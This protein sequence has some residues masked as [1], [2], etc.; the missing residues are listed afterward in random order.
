MSGNNTLGYRTRGNA[1]PQ[2][3]PRVY[4]CGHPDD[5]AGQ[6]EV[7]ADEILGL[8]ANAAIWY[9][10]PAY[11]PD[12][13]LSPDELAQMQLVVVPVTQRFLHEDCAARLEELPCAVEQHVPV[14]PVL[15]DIALASEFNRLCGDLQCLDRHA[16]EHDPT[17]LPYRE[18]LARFLG[19]VLVDDDLAARVRAAFDA[20]VFLSYRKRDRAEA[21]QVMRLIHANPLCRDIAIW[22]DEF[23][24]PGESFNQAIMDALQKS[25][26]FALVVTPSLLQNPNYVM[27]T[28]WPA[29]RDAGKPTLPIEALPTDPGQLASLY[30]GLGGTIS[31]KDRDAVGKRLEE[32][33]RGIA[34]KRRAGEPAHDYLI[35][36]AYLSGIDVE[37]DRD[38]AL[39]LITAAAEAD[40]PEACE[41]LVA[42]YRNG[43]GVV[44]SYR[45]A[46]AWQERLIEILKGRE[47][48]LRFPSARL[49]KA[50]DSLAMLKK[51]AGDAVGSR[52]AQV[53][54]LEQAMRIVDS[55]NLDGRFDIATSCI[56]LGS[57]LLGSGDPSTARAWLDK[58]R[59][60]LE[61]VLA[62]EQGE[63]FS[64]VDG[65]NGLDI[66]TFGGFVDKKLVR[67][68]LVAC[69]AHIGNTYA[70]ED[71]VD[72][73]HAWFLRSIDLL[74][75]LAA[76]EGSFASA[77]HLVLVY[78]LMARLELGEGSTAEARHWCSKG[79]AAAEELDEKNAR[80]CLMSLNDA[81]ASIC[82]A[83]GSHEEVRTYRAA[84]AS[85]AGDTEIL[86]RRR[87]IDLLIESAS[88]CEEAHDLVGACE[89]Y[90]QACV[91]SEGLIEE[92]GSAEVRIDLS[93]FRSHLVDLFLD[94]FEYDKAWDSAK[95][96]VA[97]AEQAAA[98]SDTYEAHEALGVAYERMALVHRIEHRPKDSIAS[99]E[100]TVAEFER[101]V[102]ENPDSSWKEHITDAKAAI[103]ELR[104]EIAE[105]EARRKRWHDR[106]LADTVYTL[107]KD[108]A[109]IA[110]FRELVDRYDAI[111]R[112]YRK[113][114][115]RVD[116]IYWYERELSVLGALSKTDG[117]DDVQELQE[118]ALRGLDETYISREVDPGKL[119]EV[120]PEPPVYDAGSL[121]SLPL[122]A[123]RTLSE[124]YTRYINRL[125]AA[126]DYPSMADWFQRLGEVDSVLIERSGMYETAEPLYDYIRAGRMY[127]V[128]GDADNAFAYYVMASVRIDKIDALWASGGWM[129]EDGE[130]YEPLYSV[131]DE[132]R[133]E[134]LEA[135]EWN[136]EDALKIRLKLAEKDPTLWPIRIVAMLCYKSA[137]STS[138]LKKRVAYLEEALDYGKRCIE[139]GGTEHDQLFV[140]I[141]ARE[142]H[143]WGGDV[144][145][146]RTAMKTAVVFFSLDGNTRLAACGL[147]ERL[148]ADAFE[149]RTVKPY[150]AKGPLKI[151]VGGKDATFDTCPAI[152]PLDIDLA[153]YDQ[154]VLGTPVWADKV[155][156]PINT[157]LKGRG[158]GGKS[159]ALL[160]S[161]AGGDATKCAQDA[162][163]KL[164]RTTEELP[165]LSLR[166]PTKMGA[167]DLAAQ[168]DAFATQ[169]NS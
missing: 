24:V 154:V 48:D 52:K 100:K 84:A 168:L 165:L 38:R 61:A 63:A 96:A 113:V 135:L 88:A 19:S 141:V 146:E 53:E 34:L 138:S 71:N 29:A 160:I 111:A 11:G 136:L 102:A 10:D 31:A 139:L 110:A 16:Q 97:A 64:F 14:L 25:A 143:A 12:A 106:L 119:A 157:F 116:A 81:M 117:S 70:A 76:E 105:S 39:G 144:P 127:R 114:G 166:S 57:E 142:L 79:I 80:D 93:L 164:G 133:A 169:L 40:L 67:Q 62:E 152:Q 8:Q 15:D 162:A 27:T 51:I 150:P 132:D 32:V 147:A 124:D 83:E 101:V 59:A 55:G 149:I 26:A 2:G 115:D 5:L 89:R 129:D 148:G 56:A 118:R 72:E 122:D 137:A 99:F 104:A 65:P 45:T 30:L 128:L 75:G 77:R 35:G 17:A 120:G 85:A 126:H 103:D 28:E 123:L 9:R 20:Y 50:L 54:A 108:A 69:S 159:L 58:G 94:R 121:G 109:G 1:S 161:S 13:A 18:R 107:P 91:Q 60:Y 36:L 78:E 131:S 33:L 167:A 47:G 68:A 7:I 22:Y 140:D 43:E 151:L 6:L 158:L 134:V 37:V 41:R 95:K 87:A 98:E 155:A 145:R 23:L 153:A 21:Q 46:I 86:S 130:R 112:Q 156:A 92:T 74:E 42:M 125:E 82:E 49:H 44:R 66:R 163:A 90:A 4:L 73:A 3:R